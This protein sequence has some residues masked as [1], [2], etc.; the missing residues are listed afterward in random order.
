MA[1]EVDDIV[2]GLKSGV[3]QHSS[4]VPHDVPGPAGDDVDSIMAGLKSG[5]DQQLSGAPAPA[6]KAPSAPAL[7][8]IPFAK[9]VMQLESSG[10]P[11]ARAVGSSATGAGQ[12]LK[13]TWI[14]LV[15]RERPDLADG[16]SDAEVLAMRNDPKLSEQMIDAYG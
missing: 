14:P 15:R 1:D 6:P 5:V 7:S 2:A 11:T 9:R 3:D 13:D 4:A 12:F 16:K 8:K 10:D